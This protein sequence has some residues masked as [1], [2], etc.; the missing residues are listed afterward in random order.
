LASLCG[1]INGS[2]DENSSEYIRNLIV[3]AVAT[4]EKL[5]SQPSSE[6]TDHPLASVTGEQNSK[7][8]LFTV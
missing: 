7:G 5:Q 8:N 4:I 3:K 2:L 6:T 1:E